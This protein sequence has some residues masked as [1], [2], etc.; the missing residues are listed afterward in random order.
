MLIQ[1]VKIC[2]IHTKWYIHYTSSNKYKNY[3]LK[4]N[5][6]CLVFPFRSQFYC[7]H[8]AF[9]NYSIHNFYILSI[10]IVDIKTFL[11]CYS[12]LRKE[13][14]LFRKHIKIYKNFLNAAGLEPAPPGA[15]RFPGGAGSSPATFKIFICFLNKILKHFID[16]IL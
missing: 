15:G 3:K 9:L 1:S 12:T 6:W 14:Y 10:N 5:Y 2:E 7:F 11:K 4:T 8:C 13:K 16:F